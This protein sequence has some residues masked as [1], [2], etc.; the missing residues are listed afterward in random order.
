MGTVCSHE[1][2]V[3][4]GVFVILGLIAAATAMKWSELGQIVCNVPPSIVE[5]F[6]TLI[7]I[8]GHNLGDRK[9]EESLREIQRSRLRLVDYLE[10]M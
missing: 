2:T 6:F 1:Y 7:L 10:G 4:A 5:S 8:T 3:V 9:R